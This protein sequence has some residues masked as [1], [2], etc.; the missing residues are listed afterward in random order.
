VNQEKQKQPLSLAIGYSCPLISR[1]F[2]SVLI[3]FVET[4]LVLPTTG[5][6]AHS[7]IK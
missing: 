7:I 4:V 1:G 3:D 5:A 2:I 6:Y